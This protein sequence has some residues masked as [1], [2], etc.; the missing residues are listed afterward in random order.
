[1]TMTDPIADLLT[2][3]RNAL[4]ARHDRVDI[5]VSKIKVAIIR[6]L[7]DEGF[8]KNFKISKDNRQGLIRVFLKY[9]D[10]NSPVINGLE[11]LSRPGRR[12]YQKAANISPVLSG[13]GV[14]IVSTSSGVMT[15]KE[16]RR[17]SLGGEMICQIW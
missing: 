8:I 17:Q 4:I 15:D 16:A 7:K 3:V 6:I 12:L 5:P 14:A 11:R 1:M 13:L 9:S 10:R 2:R